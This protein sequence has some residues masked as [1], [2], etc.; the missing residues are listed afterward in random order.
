MHVSTEYQTEENFLRM[1]LSTHTTEL[2]CESKY[3]RGKY[4]WVILY[5]FQSAK[6][7]G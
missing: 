1:K 3:T 7:L 5:L 2:F 4:L 6:E